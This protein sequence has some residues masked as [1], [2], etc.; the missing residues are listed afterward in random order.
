MPEP[1]TDYERLHYAWLRLAAH[2]YKAI[3]IRELVRWIDRRFP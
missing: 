3:R 2:F 1:L